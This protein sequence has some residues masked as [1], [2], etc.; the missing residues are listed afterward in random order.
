MRY[1]ARILAPLEGKDQLPTVEALAGVLPPQWIREAVEH[2][3][4]TSCRRRRL[5]AELTAW[6]VVL[7]GLFRR[8]SYANL[9]GMLGEA[10]WKSAPW[11]VEAPPCTRALSKARDRLG[12]GPLEHLFERSAREWIS[13]LAGRCVGGHRVY[14]LDGTCVLVPDSEENRDAFGAP[15]CTRGRAGYPQMRLL[16]L[17]D[18]ATHLVVAV[19]TGP[20]CEGEMTLA[21]RLLGEV[22]EEALVVLDRLFYSYELLHR[23]RVERKAHFLIRLKKHIVT[24]RLRAL[25]P[26]DFL[27]EVPA[28]PALLREHPELPPTLTLREV[29]YRPEAGSEDIR[30]LTSYLD[31]QILPTADI[32]P[33]YGDRWEEETV[34]DEIKTH[35]CG[36]AVV[37]RPTAL[38][39]QT[40]QRIQQEILGVLLA[41]NAT[42]CLM[43]QAAQEH[44][45]SPRRL[46][47][48]AALERVREAVR[49][50]MQLPTSRLLERY[51]RLLRAVARA[52]IPHRPGRHYPRAVKV[53]MSKY[54]VKRGAA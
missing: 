15:A 30:V 9:L 32:P 41:Y 47:F 4:R 19:R 16:A 8:L 45:R 22:P 27:V 17:V 51:V 44:G 18:V 33:L 49:D 43:G 5:P 25:G 48:T 10:T 7:L 6:I 39:S 34:I 21:R 14:A 1:V 3:A 52:A 2:S 37:S 11:P 35:Q 46:S 28:P 29:T 12:I 26:R 23:L 24:R 38:R 42:R 50:M 13:G 20:F 40:P 54:E 31:A 53:K 36:C